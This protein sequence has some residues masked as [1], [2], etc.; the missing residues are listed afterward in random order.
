MGFQ[1]LRYEPIGAHSADLARADQPALF[2]N[3]EVLRERGERHVE[4]AR[5][6]AHGGGPGAEG[7]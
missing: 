1:R 2:E 4:G 7:K 3:V 5:Q 6:L